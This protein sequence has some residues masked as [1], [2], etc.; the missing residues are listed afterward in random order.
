MLPDDT[1]A[2][3]AR[4]Q[5]DVLRKM[6]I[7]DRAKMTFQL[8]DN[9]RS[10]VEAGIRQRHPDYTPRQ[11]TQ[12]ALSLVMDKEIVAKAFGSNEVSP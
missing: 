7:S 12:A 4:R 1:Q 3:S 11:V 5:F 10:I 8:S 2:D 6:N 9:L